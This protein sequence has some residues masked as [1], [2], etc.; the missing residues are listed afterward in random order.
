M[1]RGVYPEPIRFALSKIPTGRHSRESGNPAPSG[2]TWTPACAGVTT[3]A[4]FISLGGLW[5]HGHSG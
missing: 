4:I 3:T 2:L 5:A 1:L